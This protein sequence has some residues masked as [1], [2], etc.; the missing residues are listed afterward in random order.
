MK[1]IQKR[2]KNHKI[3]KFLLK[4]LLFYN[5]MNCELKKKIHLDYQFEPSKNVQ[6]TIIVVIKR[7]SI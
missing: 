4:I 5:F 3:P 2:K 1:I 7:P 6:C